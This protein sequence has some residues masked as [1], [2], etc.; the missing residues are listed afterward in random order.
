[1]NAHSMMHT[2][3]SKGLTHRREQRDVG[4][5]S[6]F[7]GEAQVLTPHMAS[8]APLHEDR[9]TVAPKE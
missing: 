1:M 9:G 8:P 5:A 6:Q 2:W 3:F 4:K 7:W